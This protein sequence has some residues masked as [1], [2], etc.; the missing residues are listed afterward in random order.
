MPYDDL[1]LA[2]YHLRQ[3]DLLKR[4]NSLPS[5]GDSFLSPIFCPL[6]LIFVHTHL[7]SCL[8]A[9][10]NKTLWNLIILRGMCL[11]EFYLHDDDPIPDSEVVHASSGHFLL[12]L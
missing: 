9:W 1:A 11:L 3:T 8:L 6:L 2:S 12:A 10:V 5:Q 7:A 4:E